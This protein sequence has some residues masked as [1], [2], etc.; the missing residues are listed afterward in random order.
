[1]SD[2]RQSLADCWE[3]RAHYKLLPHDNFFE[4]FPA[5]RLHEKEE[6]MPEDQSSLLKF[7]KTGKLGVSYISSYPA[8]G[9]P[10]TVI[11]AQPWVGCDHRILGRIL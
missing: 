6:T 9:I 1:M 2:L 4:L 5:G 11:E 10:S 7:G 3:S 8:Q